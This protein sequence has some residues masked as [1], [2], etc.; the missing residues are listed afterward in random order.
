MVKWEEGV[1]KTEKLSDFRL[2][3]LISCASVHGSKEEN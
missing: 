1:E 2:T 3:T